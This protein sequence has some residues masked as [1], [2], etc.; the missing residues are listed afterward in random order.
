MAVVD[1]AVG[2]LELG[3][4]VVG[5]VLTGVDRGALLGAP[6]SRSAHLATVPLLAV[7]G[8]GKLAM[9]LGGSG[10]GR[11]FDG[12][13]ATAFL[14][15]GPWVSLAP[16]V[17]SHPSQVYEAI[18]AAIVALL[19]LMA[20][21]LDLFRAADGRRLLVALAGWGVGACG[22]VADLRVPAVVGSLPMGGLVAL[23]ITVAAVAG[24]L[25]RWSAARGTSRPRRTPGSRRGQIRRRRRGSDGPAGRGV[26]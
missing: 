19:V 8:A 26:W 11:L 12:D 24:L 14:P 1:P 13:W 16:A 20:S 6:V 9:V 25:I 15:P 18:G 2:G 17:P 21:S 10:Q 3:L 23:G 4:A 22:G 5:G 7:I